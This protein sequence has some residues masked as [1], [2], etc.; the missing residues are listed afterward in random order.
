MIY[1]PPWLG[2]YFWVNFDFSETCW[3]TLLYPWTGNFD[4]L[5]QIF[6]NRIFNDQSLVVVSGGEE[7]CLIPM[8]KK[9]I[10]KRLQK[11]VDDGI[12][13]SIYK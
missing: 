6:L 11:M 13:N 12:K 10:R 2:K 7:S 4:F 5:D 8:N 3:K 9:T 1:M